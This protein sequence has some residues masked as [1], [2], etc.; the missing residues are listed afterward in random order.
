M[1]SEAYTVDQ[2]GR[3]ERKEERKEVQCI[4]ATVTLGPVFNMP[5]HAMPCRSAYNLC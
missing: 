1:S 2:T 4:S 5:C 3:E